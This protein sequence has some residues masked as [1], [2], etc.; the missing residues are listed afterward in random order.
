MT[1]KWQKRHQALKKKSQSTPKLPTPF[2]TFL[3]ACAGH[4]LPSHP[5]V[6]RGQ[7]FFL[8]LRIS[9]LQ[10]SINYPC[11]IV[12][13]LALDCGLSGYACTIVTSLSTLKPTGFAPFGNDAVGV[14][15]TW[16]IF[17]TAWVYE[18]LQTIF[19]VLCLVGHKMK[20]LL[21]QGNGLASKKFV[22]D[23]FSILIVKKIFNISSFFK[24]EPFWWF[25][26]FAIVILFICLDKGV[27][28]F[29]FSFPQFAN[30]GSSIFVKLYAFPHCS[31]LTLT[32]RMIGVQ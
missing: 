20:P 29:S 16:I 23:F 4:E 6:C 30:F 12:D 11:F 7:I 28:F 17:V 1:Y 19:I 9:V 32:H 8:T 18:W 5:P 2:G 15:F 3:K 27:T 22:K 21:W 24:S 25:F 14:S 13:P 31:S 10:G 26:I